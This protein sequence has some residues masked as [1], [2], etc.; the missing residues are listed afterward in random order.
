[1]LFYSRLKIN[2][3]MTTNSCAFI[4]GPGKDVNKDCTKN[5]KIRD[6]SMVKFSLQLSNIKER[7]KIDGIAPK[8]FTHNT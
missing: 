5:K 1:M 7:K 8:F 4:P 3:R 2:H 6:A